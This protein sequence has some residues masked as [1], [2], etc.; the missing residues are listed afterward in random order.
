MKIIYYITDHGLGHSSRSVAIIREMIKKKINVIVRS[1]NEKFFKK[2]LPN[3]KIIL[4]KTDLTPIMQ[5]NNKLIFNKNKTKKKVSKWIK[6]IPNMIEQE[7]KIIEGINADLI[8]SDVSCMPILLAKDL[9][10]KSVVISNY[11]WNKTLELSKKDLNFIENAYSQ[12][13]LIIQ[14]P[15]SIPMKFPRQLKVGL[16]SRRIT[17]SKQEIRKKLKIPNNK[18]LIILAIGKNSNKIKYEKNIHILDISNYEELGDSGKEEM[19]EGQ[20]LINAADFVICKCGYGFISECL[21]TGTK[22][23]YITDFHHKESFAIHKYLTKLGFQNRILTENLKKITLNSKYIKN[24]KNKKMKLE[25]NSIIN[26]IFEEIK[27]DH[28]FP[29]VQ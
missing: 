24:I 4:G 21:S 25:N 14:L 10:I 7:K 15:L 20:N 26:K 19:V 5:L 1:N 2:S 12:A 6:D 13:N 22:F 28:V 8:I 9:G 16:L 27:D 17:K 18:Y 23:Q 3:V 29:K 11:T